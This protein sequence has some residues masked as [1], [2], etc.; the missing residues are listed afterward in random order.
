MWLG[1][2][3]LVSGISTTALPSWVSRARWNNLK[4]GLAV[5]PSNTLADLLT[6][7]LVSNPFLARRATLLW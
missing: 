1:G 6:L 7:L 2:F 3:M 4:N 5:R